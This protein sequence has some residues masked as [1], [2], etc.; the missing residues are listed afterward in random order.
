MS[1][2]GNGQT[3]SRTGLIASATMLFMLSTPCAAAEWVSVAKTE[4]TEVFVEDASIARSGTLVSVL[5][6]QNF[7]EPQPA[8][9]KGKTY[10][11][12]RSEY[13]VDCTARRLAYR[14]IRAYAQPDLQGDVVQKTRIGEKNLKW[15][16]A[17]KSTVFGELL[18]YSCQRAPAV[19]QSP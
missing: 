7:V 16:D 18:D 8:A 15:M 10:L 11:S 9:R 2:H 3:P 19:A 17:P 14:E 12:A 13:R 4:R 6:R 5:T 1:L